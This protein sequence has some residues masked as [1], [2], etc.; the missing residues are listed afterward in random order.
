MSNRKNASRPSESN[1]TYILDSTSGMNRNIAYRFVPG[2]A[3]KAAQ[4]AQTAGAARWVWNRVL[5]DTQAEYR[6]HC[7]T[8]RFCED[9][10][11]GMLYE[12]PSKPSLTFFSLGKRFKALRAQTPWLQNLPFAAVRYTLKRQADAWKRAFA[13]PR[14]GPSAG[15][16]LPKFKARRGDDGFTIPQDVRIRIDSVT[17]VRRLWIPKVGWCVLRRSGGNPYDAHAPKQAVIKRVLGKWYCTVCYDVPDHLVAPVDNGIAVGLDR[18]CGQVAASDGQMFWHP[19]IALLEARKRRYQ[20][21]MDRRKKG[22]KRRA[23]AR[24]RCAKTQRKIAMVRANWHHHVSRELADSAGTVVI[25]RLKVKAMT[26][27]AKGTVQAPGRN[28]K[29]KAALNRRILET[30]WAG[31][32]AKIGYKA[33]NLIEVDPAYT[34]QTCRACGVVD[35]RSRRSQSEFECVACGH[36]GNA[37]VNAALNILAR[38]TGAAGRGG[39]AVRRPV[40]RQRDVPNA[41]AKA[42]EL[43]I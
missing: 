40:K 35:A 4:V 11:I 8:E 18:N 22:S 5:A 39:G 28:V 38:G 24:H 29:V 33:A 21:M 32:G 26:A 34:S 37:D 15:S 20:R 27:S 7:D 2:S 6:L 19:D 12:R 13:D 10:L 31:L 1:G 23:V 9:T 42:V 17:G 3:S 36:Q 25:E 14:A 43:C 16:G 41:T 30:G